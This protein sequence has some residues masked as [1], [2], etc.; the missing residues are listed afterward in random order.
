VTE[1]TQ[2]Q[3]EA[4]MGTNPGA[5]SRRGETNPADNVDWRRASEFCKKL[6][7]MAQLTARLPTEA[8]WEYACLAGRKARFCFG[9][10]LKEL[11]DYAW[12][13]RNSPDPPPL[14]PSRGDG[15]RWPHV[16]PVGQKKPND[17]G[18][19]DMHGNVS[20]CCADW[21]S[22]TVLRGG[23][24]NDPPGSCTATS[25]HMVPQNGRVGFRVV[26]EAQ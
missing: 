17:W 21:H 4:L 25:G 13:R 8:E 9:D 11:D 19:Y 6:S 3:Y 14:V 12:H 2:A 7:E 15:P 24:F 23:S 1:V 5:F 20:E 10:D 16:H 26:V 22:P 18:L